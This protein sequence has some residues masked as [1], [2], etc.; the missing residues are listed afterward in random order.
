MGE[1]RRFII[2]EEQLKAYIYEAIAPSVAKG[3][4]NIKRDKTTQ[5]GLDAI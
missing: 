4:M 5:D 2:S 1:N 3:Y